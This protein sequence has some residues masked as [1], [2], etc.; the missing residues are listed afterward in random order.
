M[1]EGNVAVLLAAYNGGQHI[2]EQLDS[3]LLQENVN[4]QIYISVDFSDDNTL[5]I[6]EHYA[7]SHK[8]ITILSYGERFGCAGRNFFRLIKDVNLFN[9]DFVAFSDQDDIWPTNKL[10]SAVKFLQVYDCYSANVTAFWRDGKQELINKSQPQCEWDFLF[11]AAGPGCTYVINR[12][13]A[14]EFQT[15]LILNH[16]VITKNIALHD[17]LLYAFARANNYSWFIE[18]EPRMLYRQHENNQVGTNNNLKAAIKRLKQIKSHWYRNQ[19]VSIINILH[20]QHCSIYRFGI[21]KG[22]VGNI[23]LM[24]NVNKIRR[25]FRDRLAFFIVLLT[26]VF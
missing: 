19:V 17:W 7:D 6:C 26:N 18:Q 20:L 24:F 2:I 11:E 15:W 5:A 13:V 12:R 25:R 16:T 4:V 1:S 3:I 8:N 21:S 22:Y 23:Y 10:S 9:Y 14:L